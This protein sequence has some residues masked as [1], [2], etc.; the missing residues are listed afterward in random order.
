MFSYSYLLCVYLS[1]EASVK[2]I[3]HFFSQVVFLLLSLK[4]TWHIVDN[5]P[6]QVCVLQIFSTSLWILFLF[7][8]EIDFLFDFAP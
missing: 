8:D 6:L 4:S 2:V 3:A 1:V 5:S 7:F